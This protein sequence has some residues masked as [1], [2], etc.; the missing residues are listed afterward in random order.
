VRGQG[1][2]KLMTETNLEAAQVCSMNDEKNMVTSIEK[3]LWYTYIVYYLK[4]LKCPEG[5]DDN[6]KRTLK[7]HTLKYVL[8]EGDLYW[9]NKDGILLLCLD[10][11]QERHA[12]IEMHEG[13]CGGHFLA[14]NTAHK[15]L[16]AGYY[17]PKVFNDA[18]NYTIQCEACQ[19][20][21]R[22]LKYQGALPL[23]PMKTYAG[24]CPV[25]PV[26]N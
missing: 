14:K 19:R 1:L 4:H 3:T 20:F 2:A 7:L 15:I 26:G 17:W 8:I 23:R 11:D 24:R 10:E 16:R 6:R 13:V 25:L 12:L 22:K 5:F 18:C 21:S 9:K